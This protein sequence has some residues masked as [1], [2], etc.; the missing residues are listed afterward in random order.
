MLQTLATLLLFPILLAQGRAVRRST[1]RLPEAAGP[2]QGSTGSGPTLRL[3]VL[4]DSAGAGVGVSHQDD[5]LSGQ[6]VAALSDAYR[7]EWSVFATTGDDT[8]MTLQR[9]EDFEQGP[10]DAVVTSLGVNDVTSGISSATW[11]ARQARLRE[12]LRES[13]GVRVFVLNGLPPMHAFPA[14][15]QPLRWYLGH[16][17]RR[18]DRDLRRAIESEDGVTMLDLHFSDSED[19]AMAE[20]GF[21]PGAVVYREW[22]LGAASTVNEMMKTS[23]PG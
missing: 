19:A 2:R 6:V 20:D 10:F 18:F 12:V 9:L 23:T 21:H 4:G 5:A 7:V 11:L 15:P 16:R 14:L 22:G 17:A 1:P 13:F 8:A 3:L